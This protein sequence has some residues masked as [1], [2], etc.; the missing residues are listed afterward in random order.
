MLKNCFFSNKKAE[1][2]PFLLSSFQFPY[3]KYE[4]EQNVDIQ[5]F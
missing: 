1:E 5:K 3:N 2:N 4:V